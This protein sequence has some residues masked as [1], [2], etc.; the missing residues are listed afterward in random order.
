MRSG[1]RWACVSPSHDTRY[2]PRKA[3]DDDENI[4]VKRIKQYEK[5]MANLAAAVQV[6][7]SGLDAAISE[8]EARC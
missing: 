2:K 7:L 4:D 3:F 6:S 5:H 8:E 1:E